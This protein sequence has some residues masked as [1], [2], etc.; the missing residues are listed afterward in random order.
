M[1]R[2]EELKTELRSVVDRFPLVLT[3]AMAAICVVLYVIGNARNE[4]DFTLFL[5]W[6]FGLY[7]GI[8]LHFSAVI[9]IESRE[10]SGR[11]KIITLFVGVLLHALI[12]T[13]LLLVRHVAE[14]QKVSIFLFYI[15]SCHLLNAFLPFLVGMKK[16]FFWNFNQWMFSRFVLSTVFSGILAMGLGLAVG[17][18]QLLFISINEQLV[19][20]LIF[21]AASTMH[22]FFFFAGK[23]RELNKGNWIVE[24]A[25]PYRILIQYLLLPLVVLYLTILYFYLA[26]ILITFE[27]PKGNVSI[28]IL[29]FCT[30]GILAILL[31]EPF[32]KMESN[33]VGKFAKLFYW[34]MLPLLVMLWIA[35]NTRVLE[36]GLTETRGLVLYLAVWLTFIS[37]YNGF[38]KKKSLLAFPI[39][40]FIITF[41]YQWGGPLS[42][43]SLSFRSQ[44]TRTETL[45]AQDS[46][47][48]DEL[49]NQLN[50]MYNY[51]PEETAWLESNQLPVRGDEYTYDLVSSVLKQE[52]FRGKLKNT[53][54]QEEWEIPWVHC[55]LEHYSVQGYDESF[56][57]DV[58]EQSDSIYVRF[59]D[60]NE[61]ISHEISEPFYLFYHQL[62]S[63]Q[64]E[65]PAFT[66]EWDQGSKHYK[67]I[68]TN[69]S[70][71]PG[72]SES[73]ETNAY[74]R[75][76]V[77]L[78]K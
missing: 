20:Q 49:R 51:H 74:V 59:T 33:W 24:P 37:L 78:G 66:Q 77:V 61:K 73:Y 8:P 48:E 19:A 42:A 18:I 2:F 65:Y 71:K 45:L 25:K 35:I 22:I 39:S 64:R 50:Y 28:W 31:A 54:N 10:L 70:F 32:R 15:I 34:L 43:H 46:I 27:L 56:R 47:D 17:S 55:D 76:G 6:A 38:Y 52:R 63:D 62:K 72:Y 67:L 68:V 11:K 40:L 21:F 57:I 29:V 44:S 23:P 12:I 9:A 16:E 4:I 30:I 53:M 1:S 3:S 36:Y 58:S 41:L 75:A 7:L 60:G 69:Y 26:K 14:T 5:T 13:H